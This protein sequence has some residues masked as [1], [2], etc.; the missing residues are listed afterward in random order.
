MRTTSTILSTVTFG[1]PTT[2]EVSATALRSGRSEASRIM[3]LTL[4]GSRFLVILAQAGRGAELAVVDAFRVQVEERL[5]RGMEDGRPVSPPSSRKG[6]PRWVSSDRLSVSCSS[7]SPCS[8]DIVFLTRR[9]PNAKTM[10]TD[11]APGPAVERL[12]AKGRWKSLGRRTAPPASRIAFFSATLSPLPF[13]ALRGVLQDDAFLCQGVPDLVGQVVRFRLRSSFRTSMMISMIS[14]NWSGLSS[15]AGSMPK[16]LVEL[17]E[18]GDDALCA[19]L[20]QHLVIHQLV[21]LPDQLEQFGDRP[22]G[23]EV[24]VHLLEEARL[25]LLDQLLCVI[26][27]LAVSM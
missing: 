1:E 27:P 10:E 15:M 23:V 6:R 14:S 4:S 26:L 9:P 18:E 8:R 19:L 13:D 11:P 22:P 25:G 21:G 2:A 16:I 17:L 7:N 24:V 5:L 20:A 12:A 3:R